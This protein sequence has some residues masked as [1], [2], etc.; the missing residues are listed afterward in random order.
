MAITDQEI[1][2]VSDAARSRYGGRFQAMGKHIRTLGW[3]STEQQ[4]Y[5]FENTLRGRMDLSERSILDIGCGFGDY[6]SF[7]E[8]KG[9][10]F[11]SYLGWDITPEFLEEA[12]KR[13]AQDQRVSFEA[14]DIGASQDHK[15][16]ADFGVMLGLLNW[17]LKDANK[18]YEYSCRL[19]R[20]AFECVKHG[21]VVDF[22]SDHL[23]PEYP[24]EEAV[25]YHSPSQMLDFAFS[26]SSDVTLVHDFAPIP[27]KEFML[28]IYK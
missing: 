16:V 24:R 2:E 18:N 26:L 4:L 22:L 6:A 21:L 23:T 27:Q 20:N 19:I 9:V 12:S 3:G 15:A 5:R 14:G 25:F 11:G 28:F 8:E 17:N 13:F 7:L 10:S 1:A